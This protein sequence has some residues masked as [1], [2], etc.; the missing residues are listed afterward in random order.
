MSRSLYQLAL[1]LLLLP[2]MCAAVEEP[3]KTGALSLQD[4]IKIALR[5]NSSVLTAQ[6]VVVSARSTLVA[7]KSSYFPQISVQN[8]AFVGGSGRLLNTST[9]GTA[10]TVSQTVWDGGVR[11]AGVQGAKHGVTQQEAALARVIQTTT[12][13]VCTA[14][15]ELL[16]ARHVAEV[17]LA[18]VRYDE[19]LREQVLTRA[20]LGDAAKV[21]VLPV[22]AQLASARVNLL[23]AQ[24]AV[25]TAA[26]DLQ[27]TM[28]T[29]P[30]PGFDVQDV[31]DPNA[32]EIAPLDKCVALA[33]RSRPDLIEY[34]AATG[35]ARASVRSAAIS[36]YPIPTISAQYQHGL[37]GSISANGTQVVGGISFNVFDGGSNRA[38]YRKARA[39]QANALVQE[40]QIG[41][42]IRSAVETAYINLTTARERMIASAVSLEAANKNYETQ[43]AKY[44]QGLGI[45]L[46]LLNAEVQVVT[47][48]SDDVAARY[49]FY[50]AIAQLQYAVG[51]NGAFGEK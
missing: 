32:I 3:G 25:R 14:Y 27:A 10:L 9:T 1:G 23:S 35:A 33:L 28:G 42:D 45:T 51:S 37:S 50:E 40:D 39:N 20:Q 11:E 30:I 13:N 44:A 48:Q 29:A 41:K 34:Q 8:N 47:A 26:I 31:G 5:G 21:D 17:S 4:C 36:L 16:R 38:A 6:N 15:Y 24:N 12:Y 43:K 2:C 7:A 22:E 19:G 49:D 46:D 18:S